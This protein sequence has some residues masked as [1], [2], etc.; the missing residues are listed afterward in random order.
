MIGMTINE[1]MDK[2]YYGDEIEFKIEKRSFLLQGN[3]TGGKFLLTLDFWDTSDG[4]EPYHDY[5]LE[6]VCNSPKE[7]L[8]LFKAAKIFDGKTIYEVESKINVIFG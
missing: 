8:D 1:F 5:L 3:K 7:R 4:S 2:V 6:I